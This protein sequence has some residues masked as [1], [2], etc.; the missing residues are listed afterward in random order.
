MRTRL[1]VDGERFRDVFAPWRLQEEF[2]NL[3]LGPHRG[4]RQLA[5][6]FTS[7]LPRSHALGQ[8]QHGARSVTLRRRWLQALP[9]QSELECELF[10]PAALR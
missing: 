10:L 4:P 9:R 1:L 8:R 3:D 2:P 5:D 6:T 7:M